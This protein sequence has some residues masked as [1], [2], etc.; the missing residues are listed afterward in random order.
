MTVTLF[1]LLFLL[2]LIQEIVQ[3]TASQA[4]VWFVSYSIEL[5][6]CNYHIDWEQCSLKMYFTSAWPYAAAFFCQCSVTCG[7]GQQTRE[8][9]CMGPRGD[10]LPDHA[11]RGLTRPVSVQTCRRP[12]CHMHI[13]WHVT[14]Y[15]LVSEH[16]Y[17]FWNEKKKE[18]TFIAAVCPQCYAFSAL[19]AAVEVWGRGMLV[20]STQIWTP[21]L[22]TSVDW[23]A[24]QQLWSRAIRSP[25]A[26]LKVSKIWH[27]PKNTPSFDKSYFS[28]YN[29]IFL[30]W[31]QVFRT[32]GQLEAL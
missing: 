19:E 26:E 1:T 27:M 9:I 23:R 12:A 17:V 2:L 3:S 31:F 24:D 18:M 10:H 28:K 20:V 6:Y 13:T 5:L 15:G 16:K 22:R 29:F 11:C 8:V 14:E 4:S 32:Q 21:T 7:E 30:K 25:A